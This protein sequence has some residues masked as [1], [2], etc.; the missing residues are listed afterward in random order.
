[1]TRSF[2]I[3]LSALFALTGSARAQRIEW[4][5][6]EAPGWRTQVL[7]DKYLVSA[8]TNLYSFFPMTSSFYRSTDSG[9]TWRGTYPWGFVTF[10][11][12]LAKFEGT[13]AHDIF[14]HSPKIGWSSTNDGLL[15]TSDSGATW[16][17]VKTLPEPP[18]VYDFYFLQASRLDILAPGLDTRGRCHTLYSVNRS[19]ANIRQLATKKELSGI[20]YLT[21]ALIVDSCLYIAGYSDTSGTFIAKRELAD[22]NWSVLVVD[23]SA[24]HAVYLR[25]HDSSLLVGIELAL[26]KLSRNNFELDTLTLLPAKLQD[27]AVLA[28][29]QIVVS[30]YSEPFLTLIDSNLTTLEVLGKPM[31]AGG[32]LQVS[33]N[34]IYLL[35]GGTVQRGRLIEGVQ[36]GLFLRPADHSQ[37][38]RPLGGSDTLAATLAN[39]GDAPLSIRLSVESLQNV[40]FDQSEYQLIPHSEVDVL[41]FI[42]SITPERDT[43]KI[44]A[45]VNG[46]RHLLAEWILSVPEPILESRYVLPVV[47]VLSPTATHHRLQLQ[48]RGLRSLRIQTVKSMDGEMLHQGPLVVPQGKYTPVYFTPVKVPSGKLIVESDAPLS[49]DTIEYYVDTTSVDAYSVE[50]LTSSGRGVSFGGVTTIN[51]QVYSTASSFADTTNTVV[52]VRKHAIGVP[53]EILLAIDGPKLNGTDEALSI[54]TWGNLNLRSVVRSELLQGQGGMIVRFDTS[55]EVLG[56]DTIKFSIN[57]ASQA[58]ENLKLRLDRPESFDHGYFGDP[59][60][61]R[62]WGRSAEVRSDQQSVALSGRSTYESRYNS[63]N[64]DATATASATDSSGAVAITGLE[65]IGTGTVYSPLV[66]F[67]TVL[68][69]KSRL[70]AHFGFIPAHVEATRAG[71]LAIQGDN[72]MIAFASDGKR[73]FE[74]QGILEVHTGNLEDFFLR[75]GT[76]TGFEIQRADSSGKP[77]STYRY[78]GQPFTTPYNIIDAQILANGHMYLLIDDTYDISVIH[79]DSSGTL[80]QSV[81]LDGGHLRSD[82]G[83]QFLRLDSQIVV[84]MNT[85]DSAGVKEAVLYR[86]NWKHSHIP[87]QSAVRSRPTQPQLSL[88]PNPASTIVQIN[89]SALVLRS[90]VVDALGREQPATQHE[91]TID[92]SDL[93]SG[94]YFLHAETADGP[95]VQRFVV[96]R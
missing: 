86:I 10:Y 22:T 51:S 47:R 80:L 42:R 72:K 13:W 26:C 61:S 14:F 96:N 18:T 58:G 83:V 15:R 62:R 87:T 64:G 94:V 46:E 30:H 12:L 35:N 91:N 84:A 11:Q 19:E 75:L 21:S 43:A 3:L 17:R 85:T 49:P 38:L 79:F 56:V 9:E 1:M 69:T 77:I 23:S 28:S 50:Q 36:L 16:Q 27:M 73:L 55:G 63:D 92:V 88:Y 6:I 65:E 44:Y 78:K 32:S 53:S 2:L 31:G 57:S 45:T 24:R 8:Q 37:L 7:S 66:K 54:G 5:T 76:E 48:N 82:V 68:R 52:Q 4:T 41:A 39:F 40:V 71:R 33:G 25:E 20:D 60:Y 67:D 81:Y 29:G 70:M 90:V 95:V 89:A 34:T 93:R 74:R 59:N